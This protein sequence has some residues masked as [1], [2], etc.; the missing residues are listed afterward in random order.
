MAA[1]SPGAGKLI[2]ELV[3]RTVTG[4]SIVGLE[5]SGANI[6]N[7]GPDEELQPGDQVLLLGSRAQLEAARAL[8]VS[9]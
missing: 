6:I 9:G 8:L 3:L 4:A 5:R 2:R 1:D 7:P